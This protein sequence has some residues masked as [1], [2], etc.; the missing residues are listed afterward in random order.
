MV[1]LQTFHTGQ[2]PVYNYS[3]TVQPT[4][5][6]LSASLEDTVSGEE[7]R[8]RGFWKSIEQTAEQATDPRGY[9]SSISQM[10]DH[11]AMAWHG[12]ELSMEKLLEP[13]VDNNQQ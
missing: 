7:A 3:V 13:S 2:V 10:Y 12:A 5:Q 9:I 6:L 4:L 1:Q 8:N 11:L